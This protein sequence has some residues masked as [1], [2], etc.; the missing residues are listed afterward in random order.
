MVYYNGMIPRNLT[1]RIL[2]ALADAPVVYL[3]GARQ[4]GKSTLVKRIAE[5]FRPAKYYSLDTAAVFAAAQSDPEGFIAGLDE[6]VV[7]DEVQKTP[8][9]MSAIKSA[10]DA[11]RKPGRFLLTGSASVLALPIIS[12]SLV[13]RMELHTLWPFSQGEINHRRESFIENVFRKKMPRQTPAKISEA[14][15]LK[16]ILTGGYPEANA[17]KSKDRRDAWF[18]SYVATIL[19]RD[20]RDLANIDKLA[21]MPRLLRLLASRTTSLLNYADVSRS[22]S[23]P[24][25]TLKRYMALLEAIFLVKLLPPWATNLGK[26]LVKSP[27]LLI[28]DTGL[29]THVLDL[30]LDRLRS[31]R[32][33]LGHLLENFAAM[34]LFK[35]LGWSKKRCNICHFR[36]E[37]GFEVDLVLEDPAGQI[38]GIEVKSTSTI[39]A[40]DF[41]GLKALADIAGDRFVR[42]LVLYLGDQ[43]VPF[44][45]N[46]AALPINAL[47]A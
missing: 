47:W 43:A 21:D 2:R 15:L 4:T 23:L 45:R 36:T 34:E 40:H 5:D 31:D 20:V 18:D 10:V 42:G 44:A 16:R 17:R 26:R 29:L 8:A 1:E 33:W 38:V 13:G 46:L 12:E 19:Q 9:L 39:N 24:L 41:K 27:K 25:T 14:Q 3:Q 7:I 32:T 6:P 35:Q 28:A 11:R 22:L 37:N 30:D